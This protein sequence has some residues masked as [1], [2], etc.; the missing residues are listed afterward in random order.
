L[1]E[2]KIGESNLVT[3]KITNTKCRI[4]GEI[5]PKIIKILDYELSYPLAGYEH[6]TTAGR[7][8]SGWDG[9]VRLMDKKMQFPVG[10]WKRAGKTLVENGIQVKVE[11]LRDSP[12]GTPLPL[13]KSFK[14]RDYQLE[15]VDIAEK[16]ESGI[17]R[18]CTGSGKTSVISMLAGRFNVR[19]VIYVIGI[20][21]LYQ[22]KETIERILGV[23]CGMVGDGICEIV[24]NGINICT[25]WTAA[26]AFGEKIELIDCDVTSSQKYKPGV[27]QKALI[28]RM[29]KE[30]ELFILDECQYAAAKSLQ[31]I[32]RISESARYRFLLSGTPWREMGDDLL[33]EAV[34]GPKFYDLPATKLI[35]EGV[36]V[37]P[38][39]YF[40]NVPKMKNLHGT[41]AEV[42]NS[43]IV[44]NVTRNKMITDAVQSLVE[45]KKKVLIL[46]S[47]VEHG[48]ILFDLLK[49][50]FRIDVLNGTSSS[51]SRMNA[52][53]DMR[54]GKTDVL[55]ASKIFDQG[56]DIP[57]LDALIL[58]GS[59][60]SSARALQR[61]GRV[62]RSY[63]G[64]KWANVIEFWDN[65]KYLESHSMARLKIYK[66]EPGFQIKIEERTM[67][68]EEAPAPK[69]KS[70]KN[71]R[72]RVLPEDTNMDWC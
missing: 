63:P 20:E 67:N 29:V 42:Y 65:S 14:P 49:D 71:D 16:K 64:K 43:Y 57:E 44:R 38:K 41:Y 35:S 4:F 60:K 52:I 8:Y 36:L 25:I 23:K 33:I 66:S 56:I 37:P 48:Q 61:I 31:F 9:R 47:K 55:I 27:Q 62:I 7:I 10:L 30:A 5:D 32:H 11:D 50:N 54:E 53:K 17:I 34:S 68:E 19:T 28:Q 59:G 40:M 70:K 12:K 26:Q 51:D 2:E 45:A 6:A 22:M 1:I 72:R 69:P 21:L 13:S 18:M 24:P 15:V 39:I 58:A 46:I 3:I